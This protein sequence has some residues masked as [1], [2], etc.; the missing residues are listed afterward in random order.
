MPYVTLYD[1]HTEVL[2]PLRWGD[3]LILIDG[4]WSLNDL[5]IGGIHKLRWLNFA[6]SRPP[7]YPWLTFVH[8]CTNTVWRHRADLALKSVA[9]NFS[10]Q[11]LLE[12][13][14]PSQCSFYFEFRWFFLSNLNYG[15][16]KICLILEFKL[17]IKTEAD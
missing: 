3:K 9:C 10:M 13:H 5:S 17:P 15:R 11:L 6:H 8:Y 1:N 16:N 7:T 4:S 14:L 12:W 2:K